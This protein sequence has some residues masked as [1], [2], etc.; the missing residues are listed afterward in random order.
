MV[1]VIYIHLRLVIKNYIPITIK[2][3]QWGDYS[4]PYGT[5]VIEYT[6]IVPFNVSF[7]I[8]YPRVVCSCMSDSITNQTAVTVL[9]GEQ[10]KNSDKFT[11]RLKLL[12]EAS[13]PVIY[14][15]VYW[16]VIGY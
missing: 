16:L 5:N 10:Y 8:M 12:S 9:I 6:L 14:S 4:L 1:D 3:I 11:V 13:D 7:T 2:F 15:G